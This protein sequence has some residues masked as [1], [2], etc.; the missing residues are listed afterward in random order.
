MANFRRKGAKAPPRIILGARLNAPCSPHVTGFEIFG[1][2]LFG[3][4]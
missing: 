4:L 2:A 3:G 1:G